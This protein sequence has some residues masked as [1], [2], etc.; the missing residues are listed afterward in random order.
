MRLR[1][2]YFMEYD[3][4][5]IITNWLFKSDEAVKE[6]L[7]N[8]E[9]NNLASAQNRIYY[10]LFYSV[11]ALGYYKDFTTSKHT[12]LIG[13]FNREFIKTGIFSKEMGK[14]YNDAY[15]FRSKSDYTITYKPQKENILKLLKDS[16]TFIETIKAY[17]K[18]D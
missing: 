17:I 11:M 16:T 12:E 8:L 6:T 15:E 13:W 18:L 3:K 7:D 9:L 4:H 10:A 2:A 14:T 5:T 1:R